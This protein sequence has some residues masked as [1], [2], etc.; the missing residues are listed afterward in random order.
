MYLSEIYLQSGLHS[1]NVQRRQHLNIGSILKYN[2]KDRLTGLQHTSRMRE[3][4]L[5]IK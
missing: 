1:H 3:N 4:L 2:K 5:D